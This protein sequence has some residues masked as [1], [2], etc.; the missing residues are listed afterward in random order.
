MDHVFSVNTANMSCEGTMDK[1]DRLQLRIDPG[2]KEWFR[3]FAKTRGGMSKI[4]Q[5]QLEKL[6]QAEDDNGRP[7]E[8]TRD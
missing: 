3:G 5:A 4:V 6:K 1:S 8:R 7:E 2:L